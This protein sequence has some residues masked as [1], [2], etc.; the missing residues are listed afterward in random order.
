M[1]LHDVTIQKAG[2]DALDENVAAFTQTAVATKAA[3]I[4][5][6]DEQRDEE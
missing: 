5:K 2:G 6:E 3:V 1:L 4:T